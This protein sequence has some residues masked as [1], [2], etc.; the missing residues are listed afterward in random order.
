MS[1]SLGHRRKLCFW[2]WGYEDEALTA[3]EIDH[4]GDVFL[5][6]KF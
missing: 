2:G 1:D 3:G 4:F 6:W 5:V